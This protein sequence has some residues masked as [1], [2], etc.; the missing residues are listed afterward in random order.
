MDF[1]NAPGFRTFW[2]TVMVIIWIVIMVGLIKSA[3]NSLKRTGGKLKSVFDEVIVGI[4]ISVAFVLIA[5]QNPS[6]II[7]WIGNI[8]KWVWNL[9]LS[10]LRFVGL[11]V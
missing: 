6:T 5:L 7:S 8:L 9:L 4:I 1:T 11:P 10:L 2:Y 3:M